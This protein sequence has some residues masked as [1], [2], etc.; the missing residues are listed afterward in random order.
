MSKP[1][2]TDPD[3][4]TPAHD[5]I[6]MWLEENAER[7]IFEYGQVEKSFNSACKNVSDTLLENTLPIKAVDNSVDLAIRAELDANVETA[8]EYPLRFGGGSRY[9]DMMVDV[10]WYEPRAYVAT[11]AETKWAGWFELSWDAKVLLVEA[12]RRRVKLACEVKPVIRSVGELIRQLRQYESSDWKV[13]VV[14]PDDRFRDIIEKQG[15]IF[16]KAPQPEYG[17]QGGLF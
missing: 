2:F 6:M 5:A 12:N 3:L 15:F 10:A 4:H 16:I 1:T 11:N 13:A 7:L 17:P 9:V 14:S 8:W